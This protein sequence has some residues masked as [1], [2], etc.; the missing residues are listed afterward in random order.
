MS[1]KIETTMNRIVNYLEN[2]PLGR[3]EEEI[4]RKLSNKYD[5][6]NLEEEVPKALEE[7]ENEGRVLNIREDEYKL[8]G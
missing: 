2:C 6:E 5:V 3:S 4:I 1:T 7:L 8:L